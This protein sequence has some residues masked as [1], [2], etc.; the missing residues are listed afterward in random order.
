[1]PKFDGATVPRSSPFSD[2]FEAART[3]NVDMLI[4]ALAGGASLEQREAD[5]QRNPFHVAVAS[6]SM[7]FLRAA[8][9]QPEVDLFARDRG[10]LRPLDLCWIVNDMEMHTLIHAA[11]F[12][13]G[14]FLTV[15]WER[16]P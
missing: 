14:W 1:M 16:A 6:G 10:G 2:I 5:T 11:M 12:P 13:P 3:D 7:K 9:T 15:E 8:V 4:A